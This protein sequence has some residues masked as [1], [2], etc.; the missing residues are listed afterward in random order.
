MTDDASL[1]PLLRKKYF[2]WE[3][4]NFNT[5]PTL[6]ILK[7]NYGGSNNTT[8]ASY[9]TFSNRSTIT[10][11]GQSQ[12]AAN[13]NKYKN[14]AINII[15]AQY[16]ISNAINNL[17]TDYALAQRCDT[18]S[19]YSG[20]NTIGCCKNSGIKPICSQ[21]FSNFADVN[22]T[23][24]S[25]ITVNPILQLQDYMYVDTGKKSFCQQVNDISGLIQ[26]LKTIYTTNWNYQT[27]SD[28]IAAN[29][30]TNYQRMLKLR[31]ELD[32]KLQSLLNKTDNNNIQYQNK[33]QLDSTVYTT[34]LWTVLATSIL[35]YVF[36]KI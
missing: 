16:Y 29:I 24:G 20:N 26:D 17:A 25:S 2:L 23:P 6:A 34:V 8:C 15:E 31:N 5:R 28:D 12:P 33:L 30:E 1:N 9:Y 11:T 4:P 35:Y 14:S 32:L 27:I 21:T 7:G 13:F 22:Y 3:S 19:R 36:I 10:S 18:S